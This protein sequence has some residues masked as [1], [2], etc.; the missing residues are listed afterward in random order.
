MRDVEKRSRVP[1]NIPSCVLFNVAVRI[2]YLVVRVLEA[3]D[4]AS[5]ENAAEHHGRFRLAELDAAN[6]TLSHRPRG[7]ACGCPCDSR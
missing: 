2:R 3:R 4:D 5:V 6:E 1:A 7:L